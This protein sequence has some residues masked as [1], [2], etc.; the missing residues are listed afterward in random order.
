[1]F[2]NSVCCGASRLSCHVCGILPLHP[3]T[4]QA[5]AGKDSQRS[6]WVGLKPCVG[7]RMEWKLSR[8]RHL[9]PHLKNGV[10]VPG[11]TGWKRTSF[12]KLPSD[13]QTLA[14]VCTSPIHCA[15]PCSTI[16]VSHT[17]TNV[18]L[19]A[20]KIKAVLRTNLSH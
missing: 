7:R 11:S 8:E 2:D 5:E 4:G 3:S 13:P 9:Q 12:G 15:H 17:H 14:E 16:A 19:K 20:N 18:T 1:M 6:A 10:Q